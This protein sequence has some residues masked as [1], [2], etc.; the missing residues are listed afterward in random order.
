MKAGSALLLSIAALACVPSAPPA[1]APGN[2]AAADTLRGTVR[3]VGS[4]PG[5]W[6][7]LQPAAQRAVSL[8]GRAAEPLRSVSGADVWVRGRAVEW[9]FEVTEF[10]V[11]AVDG[12]QT[13]DGVLRRN[14]QTLAL[15]LSEGGTAELRDPPQALYQYVGSRI[16]ITRPVAGRGAAYGV[17]ATR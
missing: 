12:Q 14:G 13:W 1:D 8:G 15:E 17:I 10:A 2:S 7:T 3:I 6:I 4:D 9:Y 16:W 11:R 5:T